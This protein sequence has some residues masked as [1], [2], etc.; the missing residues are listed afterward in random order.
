MLAL[1]IPLILV[2]ER[3]NLCYIGYLPGYF[4]KPL[5]LVYSIKSKNMFLE[6]V[7]DFLLPC[8]FKIVSP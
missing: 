7:P 1:S 5:E 6:V 3:L 2:I 8:Y 4:N